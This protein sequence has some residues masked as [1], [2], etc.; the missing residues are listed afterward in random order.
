MGVGKGMGRAG[1]RG[2]RESGIKNLSEWSERGEGKGVTE[3]G[4]GRERL[5][6]G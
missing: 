2:G 1:R 4:G 3:G 5:K 6:G